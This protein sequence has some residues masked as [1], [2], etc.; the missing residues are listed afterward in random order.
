MGNVGTLG[1]CAGCCHQV[2]KG[3][4]TL[5]YTTTV[6]AYDCA[7]ATPRQAALAE[8]RSKGLVPVIELLQEPKF[9]PPHTSDDKLSPVP[10]NTDRQHATGRTAHSEAGEAT[11]SRA[12]TT[13]SQSSAAL[14]AAGSATTADT[15]TPGQVGQAQEVVKSFVRALVKGRPISV[16]S[17]SGGLAA[18]VVSVD[19][20]LTTLTLK[21]GEKK[22]GKKRGIPLESVAEICVGEDC[23]EEIELPVNELCVT[24]LLEDGQAVGFQFEDNEDRDTFALCLSMFVDGRRGEI[25]RKSA[26]KGSSRQSSSVGGG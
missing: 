1:T 3:E 10:E 5:S 23:G 15:A 11:L 18:V 26:E 2:S 12:G 22:E 13:L 24:L 20:K 21:R 19:R 14:S 17:L 7:V 6:Q 25:C 8:E 4:S 16:L 9:P